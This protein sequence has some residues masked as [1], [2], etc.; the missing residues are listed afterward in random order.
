MKNATRDSIRICPECAAE[1]SPFSDNCWLCQ[2]P[3]TG[4]VEIVTAEIVGE[5]RPNPILDRT[6]AVLTGLVGLLIVIVGIGI[7]ADEPSLGVL[8]VLVVTPPLLGAFV[9][10]KR[11]MRRRRYV[12]W[13]E[14]LAT[15]IVSFALMYGLLMALGVAALVAFFIYCVI[16]LST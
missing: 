2:C 7:A 12:G 16:A 11:E 14:R 3:L 1:N 4:D 8:Y 15:L 13:G 5:N 10:V 6:F 9:R